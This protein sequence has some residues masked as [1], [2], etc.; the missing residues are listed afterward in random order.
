MSILQ[1]GRRKLC[2]CHPLPQY[3]LLS[4]KWWF[5]KTQGKLRKAVFLPT[6]KDT[7]CALKTNTSVLPQDSWMLA[8]SFL[9]S[10]QA[11]FRQGNSPHCPF[12]TLTSLQRWVL[13]KQQVSRA[14]TQQHKEDSSEPLC[15]ATPKICSGKKTQTNPKHFSDIQCH[16]EKSLYPVCMASLNSSDCPWSSQIDQEIQTQE[17]LPANLRGG[18]NNNTAQLYSST[19]LAF[20]ASSQISVKTIL[21]A[22]CL[23]GSSISKNSG[24]GQQGKMVMMKIAS[25]NLLS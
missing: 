2:T 17:H 7:D 9:L 19:F 3:P 24:R 8:S 23:I 16:S 14:V 25:E 15:I 10:L 13:Q 12:S 5:P 20:T 6:E 22:S 18:R 21:R 11:L 1:R 4:T